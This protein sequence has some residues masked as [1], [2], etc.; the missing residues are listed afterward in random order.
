MEGRV[1]VLTGGRLYGWAWDRSRPAETMEI[2]VRIGD[3]ILAAAPADH[4]REDLKA[5]GI[6][7]GRH[8]FEIPLDL[9]Q[10]S[11]FDVIARSP[12][13]GEILSL[14]Q[15]SDSEAV[16]DGV[17]GPTLVR[18]SA[19]MDEAQRLQQAVHGG[20]QTILRGIRE[21]LKQV[22]GSAD[23]THTLNLIR[24]AQ[25]DAEKQATGIEVFLLRIDESLRELNSGLARRPQPGA[26]RILRV[27]VAGFGGLSTLILCA[28]AAHQF[29]LV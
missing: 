29:G 18:M 13:T 3:R 11:A 21:L 5:N 20:Q 9:E 2:E 17:P 12:A 6:G 23:L 7:G 25:E 15:A 24:E 27:M 16:A 28:I 1:D 10:G 26:D 19:L 22:Q 4:L 8:A 14:R